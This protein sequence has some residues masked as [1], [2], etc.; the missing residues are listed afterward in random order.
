MR[1]TLLANITQLID[2]EREV[3]QRKKHRRNAQQV[4]AE[5]PMYARFVNEER[6]THTTRL[7]I[8]FTDR[9]VPLSARRPTLLSCPR[10]RESRA[11]H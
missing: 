8:L 3:H 6:L 7:P 1:S 5:L 2:A 4:Q 10:K 11:T 9:S